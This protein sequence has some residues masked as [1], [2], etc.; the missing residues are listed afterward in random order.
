MKSRKHFPVP[1]IIFTLVLAVTASGA[2]AQSGGL[3]AGTYRCSS[4]NVSGG[5]G[6]CRTMQPLLL[7]PDGTYQYSST[8]GHWSIQN[9]KLF[10]SDS[11]LWGDGA[12]L[13]NDTIRFEYDYRGLRHV[14]TWICRE[15]ARADSKDVAPVKARAAAPEVAYVGVSLTLEF[16]TAVGGLSNF[17]IVPVEFAVSYTHNVPLP[18][19]AVQGIAWETSSTTVA[20]ATNQNNKLMSGKR[21]VVF[22]SW[23]RETIPVTIL[24]LPS[25]N[26]DYQATLKATLDGAGVLAQIDQR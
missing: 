24:D 20:L 1:A 26:K 14:V 12:I 15:Y 22:L 9:G 21:Y 8:R 11:K 5:G 18:A 4:Y 17:T 7:D 13:G 6:S 19:G 23:P 10:L 3:I 25:T 16:G 2:E